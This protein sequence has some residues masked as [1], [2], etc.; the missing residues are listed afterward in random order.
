MKDKKLKQL[1]LVKRLLLA[2]IILYIAVFFIMNSPYMTADNIKR[3]YFD[4]KSA[5]TQS[6]PSS[7]DTIPL[8]DGAMNKTVLFK[9]GLCH[10][11]QNILTVYS[12][13]MKKYSEHT[14][15]IRTP[16]LKTSGKYILAFDRDGNNIYVADSFRLLKT[17]TTDEKI[18]NAGLD[19]NGYF[20]VITE[21]Y[22]YKARLTVYDREFDEVFYW[23]CADNYV[24]DAVFG[25]KHTI[26]TVTLQ[27]EKE[28]INTVIYKLDYISAKEISQIK[29]EE[30]LP[31]ACYLKTDDSVELITN[32]DIVSIRDGG[33][34]LLYT[35]NSF[36]VDRFMQS[37]RYTLIAKTSSQSAK[38]DE[39]TAIDHAGNI[40]FSKE[41]SNVG[42]VCIVSDKFM[43]LSSGVLYVLNSGGN[44]LYSYAVRNGA[45]RICANKDVCIAV[46]A[47]FAQYLDIYSKVKI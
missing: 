3:V 20:Y 28:K 9:D 13:D 23:D 29:L 36:N 4:V 27:S 43:V 45:G 16:V 12:R 19:E 17:F 32:K 31:V 2:T 33:Y 25:G 30:R 22:G 47:D 7:D 35:F 5:I 8:S 37:D 41:F 40:L 39:I 34:N 11:S 14:V 42:D 10:L 21:K 6:R 38:T 44:E 46:G 18:I 24:F 26:T 15:N 1:Y